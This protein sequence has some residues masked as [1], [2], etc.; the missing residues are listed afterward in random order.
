MCG[1]GSGGGP[2][3]CTPLP[4]T[5]AGCVR[6]GA[7]RTRR[8]PYLAAEEM[9]EHAAALQVPDDYEAPAVADEDLVGVPGMFLQSLH[10][11]K[12][13]PVAGLLWQPERGNTVSQVTGHRQGMAESAATRQLHPQ[14]PQSSGR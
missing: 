3:A 12:R 14:H 11:L 9:R 4:Q 10:H 13:P 6:R 5:G 2:I 8:H 1:L 7:G